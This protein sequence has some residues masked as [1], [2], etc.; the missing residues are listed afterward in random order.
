MVAELIGG[1]RRQFDPVAIPAVCFT[2]PEIVIGLSP[3]EAGARGAD[4]V[5][6]QFPFAANGRA[7]SMEA[8]EDGGFVR[9][10]ARSDDHR[11]LGVQAVGAQVSELV[12]EFTFSRTWPRPSMPTQP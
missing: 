12:G 9:V 3:G 6:T 2:D 10:V 4:L 5:V 7:L 1:A 11:V 8:G